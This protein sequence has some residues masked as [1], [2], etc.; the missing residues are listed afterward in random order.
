MRKTWETVGAVVIGLAV[1][2]LILLYKA[3]S[4]LLGRIDDW[5][6]NRRKKG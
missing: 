3:L 4:P 6:Y 1:V 5:F 2:P